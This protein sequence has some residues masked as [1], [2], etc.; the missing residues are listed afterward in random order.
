M[1]GTRPV[2]GAPKPRR[3]SYQPPAALEALG[4]RSDPFTIIQAAH[5]TALALL[6]TGRA[7]DDPAVAQRLVAIVDEVGLDTLADL[8]A[9]RP[10]RSLPG[11]LWR[12][13]LLREWTRADPDGAARDYAAGIRF[14]EPDHAV[15]GV[16][17]P[18]PDEIR[19]VADQILR[20]VFTGDF[21]I[22]LER[23]AAFC[24][25]V[26]SGRGDLCVGM[27]ELRHALRVQQMAVDLAACAN[28]WR[29]GGLG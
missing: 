22:A 8:W 24:N 21:A 7:A 11:A 1:D 9:D 28:L 27:E 10:A 25:V 14:N 20:G 6:H 16:D 23:A 17:P 18:G 19:R 3:P 15:A 26:S 12:L 5:E 2:S 29:A 13:Y 4:V